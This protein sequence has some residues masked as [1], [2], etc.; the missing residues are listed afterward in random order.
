[1]ST[2]KKLKVAV[3]ET[4]PV[5]VEGE[6]LSFDWSGDELTISDGH[7]VIAVFTSGQWQYVLVV[8]STDEAE[9]PEASST[10]QAAA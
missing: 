6:D 5:V 7:E 1:M 3:Y 9:E 8:E 10:E 4:D 2:V